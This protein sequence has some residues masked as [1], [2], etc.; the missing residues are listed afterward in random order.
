[1]KMKMKIVLR[2]IAV[3]LLAGL[4]AQLSCAEETDRPEYYFGA[5][6]SFVNELNDCGVRYSEAGKVKDVYRIF[7][8]HG[9]NIVRIRIWHTPDWTAYSTLPDVKRSI[10]RARDAGM[11]VLLDFHYSDDW[12]DGG[13]QIIPKAWAKL[14]SKEAE[15]KA[16]YDYTFGVLEEL[17]AE[18]LLPEMVQVGN[19]TNGEMMRPTRETPNHP[20]NWNRNAALFNAGIKAV[21]DMSEVAGQNIGVML[22]IAQPENVEPWFE[23]ASKAGILDYDYI[24]VSYYRKW[25]SETLAGLGKVINRLRHQYDAGVILV[26]TAYPWTNGHNDDSVNLLG[27]DTLIPEYPATVD[28]QR[29]YMLDLSQ[30]VIA[31]GGVGV[32]YWEPAWVS[33]SCK[34][35]WGTGSS[36]ENAAFFDF[37]PERKLLPAIDYLDYKYSYPVSVTF[38]LEVTDPAAPEWVVLKG[39]FLGEGVKVTLERTGNIFRYQTRLMPGQ[40]I[41]YQF[42][43]GG[44]QGPAAIGGKGVHEAGYVSAKVGSTS[45]R[46]HHQVK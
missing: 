23:A 1:M 5:D 7:K 8:D 18:G 22:H 14:G 6:L 34:T 26:E 13:V 38:E 31:N 19:E 43:L 45:T 44:Q 39:D 4:T 25:S 33:S 17:N 2:N 20:I 9:A 37:S 35:R 24:G 11:Q 10:K 41:Q 28:G 46:F 29:Q 32:V 12:A 40:D 15:A 30:L 21:R 3:L 36:W 27:P 16:L 42:F